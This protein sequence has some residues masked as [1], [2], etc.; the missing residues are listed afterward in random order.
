VTIFSGIQPTGDKHL[1]NY[2]GGFRQYAQTQELGEA[3]F[4][5]VD[6]H[7][8]TVEYDPRDLHERTLD[9][10]TM[11]VATGLDPA[12]S[13]VFA[14]SHVT[15]HA[16]ASWLLSAVTSYGQLGR[17]TQFKEKGGAREFVSAGLFTYPVLM[18]G[19]ILLY[20][21]D[22]VPIGDDQRQHLELARDV[23]ERFNVRFGQTFVVPDGIY[24]EVGA[25]IMDLQEPTKKMSTTGGTEQGTVKLLDAPDVIR[26]KFRSAQTDSGREIRRGDDKPGITNLIDILAVVSERTPEE[27]EQAYDGSGYGD[28]KSD[29]GDAVAER[30]TAVRERY[31]ELRADEGEL[32]RLLAV[33][34]NRAREAAEPTLTAMYERMG[35][36]RLG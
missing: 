27:I 8:I 25:R 18:A 24:P 33:G 11:L 23:A 16:E 3:F 12:R 5:I 21:A 35:F 36:V 9:L 31:L 22:K 26:K 34:A 1:G 32:R 30:L 7:S 2:I 19:D 15:A 20:Q 6:L 17:M 14:Q 28:F 10:F 13:T 4:C 29:V